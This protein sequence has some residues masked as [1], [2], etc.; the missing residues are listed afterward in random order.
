MA[1]TRT[2]I[3]EA[4]AAEIAASGLTGFSIQGVADRAGVTHRTV[5]NHFPTR[6][7]L[8]DARATVTA[9][10]ALG[11]GGNGKGTLVP[12]Q[13]REKPAS[14]AVLEYITR[15]PGSRSEEI[16]AELGTDAPGLRAV[17]HGLRDEG[18]IRAEGKARAT[19]Y[20]AVQ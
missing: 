15:H 5:Y 16:A 17:L 7:A 11:G 9:C 4:V 10:L 2:A 6:E 12:R 8:N 14:E 3:L 13:R 18:R 20:T 19:R 1:E